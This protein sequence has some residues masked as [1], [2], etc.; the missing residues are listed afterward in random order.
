VRFQYD[1]SDQD[2]ISDGSTFVDDVTID[3]APL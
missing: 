2:S 3:P 1:Y